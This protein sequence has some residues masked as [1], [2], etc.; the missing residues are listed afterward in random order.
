MSRQKTFTVL[1]LGL[2]LVFGVLIGLL[3]VFSEEGSKLTLSEYFQQLEPIIS[4]IDD[5]SGAQVVGEPADAFALWA[6]VLD[7]TAQDLRDIDPP[8]LVARDHRDLADA[9]AEGAQRMVA[10]SDLYPVVETLEEAERLINDD[11]DA[12]A[13]DSRAVLACQGL[14]QVAEDNGFDIRLE[15]C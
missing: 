13:I 11:E 10:M 6:L 12:K 2:V 4:G 1:I 5:R 9:F 15:Y 3:A 7:F 8:A 14:R